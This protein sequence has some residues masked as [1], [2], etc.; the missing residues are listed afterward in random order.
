MMYREKQLINEF[1]KT[2]NERN[3]LSIAANLNI[4][5]KEAIEKLKRKYNIKTFKEGLEVIT[6]FDPKN[7][8]SYYPSGHTYYLND[9]HIWFDINT[10]EYWNLD[11]IGKEIFDQTL[12]PYSGHMCIAS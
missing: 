7:P 5:E 9:K 12:I 10:H 8:D 4:S 11:H 2:L 3:G 6:G 1:F